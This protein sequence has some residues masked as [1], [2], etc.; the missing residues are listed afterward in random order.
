MIKQSIVTVQTDIFPGENQ[1]SMS[2]M[3]THTQHKKEESSFQAVPFFIQWL[4]VVSSICGTLVM[5]NFGE[6]QLARLT[7]FL[8]FLPG[9]CIWV[10]FA[11]QIRSVQLIFLN[12]IFLILSLVGVAN[13]LTS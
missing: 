1:Q 5:A 10:W 13:N 7:A 9:N 4:A 3:G 2:I 6:I 12:S 11:L 8:I